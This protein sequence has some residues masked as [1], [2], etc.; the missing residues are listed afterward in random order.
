MPIRYDISVEDPKTHRIQVVVD[1]PEVAGASLD[2]VLPSWVPG[3][4]VIRDQ[5]RTVR[6]VR[7][8]QAGTR[9]PLSVS[10]Q[11]KARWRVSTGGASHIEVRFEVYGHDLSVEGVDATSEHLFLNAGMC[12]PYVDGRDREPLE[13]AVHVPSTWRVYTELPEVGRSPARF[14]ARDY[15]ELVDEP[16]DCGTPTELTVRPSGIPH[17]I[18]FCGRGGNFEAHQV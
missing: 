7:A 15:D 8:I 14:R 1:V 17:R 3:S 18:L 6:N 16:I 9:T 10:K 13:V 4:Y 5:A 12:L 2:L 11:D